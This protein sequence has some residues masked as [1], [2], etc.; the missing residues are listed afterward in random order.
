MVLRDPLPP[1]QRHQALTR[2]G[3]PALGA[4]QLEE[5]GNQIDVADRL[6]DLTELLAEDA[7]AGVLAGP[8]SQLTHT[9]SLACLGRARYAFDMAIMLSK[10]YEAFRAAGAPDDKA[11]D[12][13]VEIATYENRLANIEAD[14][15]LLKWMV[16]LVLAG[17]LSLV[18]KTF[19][20]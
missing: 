7:V 1:Q 4:H 20:S 16:G 12:A 17:V 15:R 11:R 19:L 14:V 9:L 5:R 8:R 10:T 18:V 13:A 6:L 2:Q 3:G